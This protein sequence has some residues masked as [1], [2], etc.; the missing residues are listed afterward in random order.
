LDTLEQT[1]FCPAT[2]FNFQN[3]LLS[4]FVATG[5]NLIERVFDSLKQQQLKTLKIKTDIQ[6]SDSF[7]AMSNHR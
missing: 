3:R 1:P 5:E 2:F 7:M 6:R 4:H